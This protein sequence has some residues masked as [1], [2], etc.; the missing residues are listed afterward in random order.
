MIKAYI[1][2]AIEGV[3]ANKAAKELTGLD[4]VENAHLIYGEY[5]LIALVKSK[6][7]IDLKEL[8]LEKIGKVKGVVKT[9]TLIIADN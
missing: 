8:T 9:S 2:I 1:L 7:L 6:N 5:D 4:E 3:D